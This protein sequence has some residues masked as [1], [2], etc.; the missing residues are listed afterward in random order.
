MYSVNPRQGGDGSILFGGWAPRQHELLEYVAQDPRRQTDDGL[1]D[2]EPVTEA[3][4]EFGTNGFQWY[5]F[6]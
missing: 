2:F 1:T 3:V 4:R 6:S 5:V